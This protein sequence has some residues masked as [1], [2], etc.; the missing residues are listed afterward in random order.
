M[1][2][3]Q[4]QRLHWMLLYAIHSLN[5]CWA[6]LQ[7]YIFPAFDLSMWPWLSAYMLIV[8]YMT[9]S[10]HPL[11]LY[12]LEDLKVVLRMPKKFTKHFRWK[13]CSLHTD[14]T[15][16]QSLL[17][18]QSTRG[19]RGKGQYPVKSVYSPTTELEVH[20]LFIYLYAYFLCDE[21]KSYITSA[22]VHWSFI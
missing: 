18:Q 13:G 7:V 20:Y 9:N 17:P 10:E 8:D 4:C 1:F 21:V 19:T 12:M 15:A 5:L 22:R 11:I 3:S 16:L 2:W 14:W 6:V